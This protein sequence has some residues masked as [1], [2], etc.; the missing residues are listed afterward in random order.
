M[1]EDKLRIEFLGGAG[2]VTGSKTLLE[3]NG[4]RILIDCGMFQ[5]LKDLRLKNR[6]EFPVPPN[7]IDAIILTHAHLDH[8][9]YIPVLVKNGFKGAIHC[10]YPT[11]DI[12]EIILRDSGKIQEEDAERAARHSYSK[13]KKVKPLYTEKDAILASKQFVAHEFETTVKVNDDFKAHFHPNGHILGSSMVEIEVD[14]KTLL[15]SGDLGRVKS[16]LLSSPVPPPN[17]DYLILE[18]TYGDRLHKH[19]NAQEQLEKVILHT[20]EKGGVLLIP[21]FAVERTQEII[22]LL[23]QLKKK[24]VLPNQPIYLDSP[25]G[26]DVSE[27]FSKCSKWSKLN[28]TEIEDIFS[29]VKEITTIEVSKAIVSDQN[30]KIVL[31]GSGMLEGGRII[32][33]LNRWLSNEKTSILL[34]GYQAVGT[35][36]RELETGAPEIKFFGEYH[37]VK[38][39]IFKITSLSG[40]ADRN[41]ILH[42]L[43]Q[44]PSNQY[45]KIFI[46]HGE[47]QPAQALAT[48]I[49]DEFNWDV[50]VPQYKSRYIIQ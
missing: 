41:E 5:G 48:K 46:N 28:K 27:V 15:F 18:S 50:E 9:G 49:R 22:F 6:E 20:F 16:H 29:V 24:G 13:H 14:G 35:R 36:G 7:S 40:H 31:A 45:K 44:S 2:T 38:A 34:T 4:K 12:T 33:Y 17:A 3:I 47:P 42:W 23:S 11:R 30:P 19:Q 43:K 37:S 8:S 21:T 26:I 10:T 1:Y 39:E 25:M 32:H